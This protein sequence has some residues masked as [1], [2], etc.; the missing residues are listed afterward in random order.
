MPRFFNEKYIG[1]AKGREQA[2]AYHFPKTGS[3]G[4][5]N[6]LCKS[7]SPSL[8][9]ILILIDLFHIGVSPPVKH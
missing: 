2:L 6:G 8:V 3:H 9:I 5:G 1:M 7:L 4:D